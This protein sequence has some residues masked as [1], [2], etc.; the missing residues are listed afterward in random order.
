[1]SKRAT[2]QKTFVG[3]VGRIL[4]HQDQSSAGLRHLGS[5]ERSQMLEQTNGLD[6]HVT[7]LDM[8]LIQTDS[9]TTTLFNL[10]WLYP[11]NPGSAIAQL[12]GSR[13]PA[14][15]QALFLSFPIVSYWLG[16]AS[17][18]MPVRLVWELSFLLSSARFL[19]RRPD[20]DFATKRPRARLD[21]IKARL[22]VLAYVQQH[23]HDHLSSSFGPSALKYVQLATMPANSAWKMRKKQFLKP[24]EIPG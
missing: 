23:T 18:S 4:R 8:T 20:L 10:F 19:P 7:R 11:F 12:A 21:S 3:V 17:S 14:P 5:G 9:T 1:M 2:Y 22:G 16:R 15:S 6:W 13:Y 24:V